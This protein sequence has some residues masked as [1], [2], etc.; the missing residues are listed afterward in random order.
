[1]GG[2]RTCQGLP[3]ARLHFV[4][5]YPIEPTFHKALSNVFNGSPR[6]RKRLGHLGFVPAISQFQ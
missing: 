5:E 2:L 4:M 1:M 3:S 6:H